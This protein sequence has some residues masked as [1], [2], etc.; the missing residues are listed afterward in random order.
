MFFFL[1]LSYMNG[2]KNLMRSIS[3]WEGIRR[4]WRILAFCCQSE[5]SGEHCNDDIH[6][7]IRTASTVPLLISDLKL[8]YSINLWIWRIKWIDVHRR[9]KS[10]A[11]DVDLNGWSLRSSHLHLDQ[12]VR[13]SPC[14][15]LFDHRETRKY[16]RRPADC[17]QVGRL[18]TMRDLFR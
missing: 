14:S 17:C 15:E 7:I 10:S 12:T 6:H 1:R 3:S 18:T 13:Y 9:G 11:R 4:M 16:T 5:T 2:D 8:P